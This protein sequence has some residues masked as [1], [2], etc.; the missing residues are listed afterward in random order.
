[1]TIPLDKD[2]LREALKSLNDLTIL[3]DSPLIALFRLQH[4]ENPARALQTLL[5]QSIEAFRLAP[6]AVTE[7]RTYRVLHCRYILR[8]TQFATANEVGITPRHLRREQTKAIDALSHYLMVRYDLGDEE[9]EDTAAFLPDPSE[10]VELNRELA[11][12]ASQQ[13]DRICDTTAVLR[14]AIALTQGL[15]STGEVELR[16]TAELAEPWMAMPHTVAKQVVLN[17]LSSMVQVMP[18]GSRIDLLARRRHRTVVITLL[19]NSALQMAWGEQ[20]ALASAMGMSR[21]LVEAFGGRFVSTELNDVLVVKISVPSGQRQ[22]TVLAIEDNPDTLELW[23]RYIHG[24]RFNLVTESDPRRAVASALAHSPSIIVLDVMLGDADGW[25]I[26][27]QLRTHAGTSDVPVIIC[28]VLPQRSLALSLG[29]SDFIPKPT[30][31]CTF[32]EALER[33]SGHQNGAEALEPEPL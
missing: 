17:L 22:V 24:T 28:T 27:S 8:M 30:T 10:S 19:A 15:G 26:L 23:R 3:G 9:L 7:N 2:L 32:R 11:W 18:P 4:Q 21:R 31:G 14:E 25:D 20:S 6:S 33:Q 29:A 1:M 12:L 13:G 16:L 5:Q